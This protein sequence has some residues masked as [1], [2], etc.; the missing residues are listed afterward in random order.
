MKL[1]NIF[2]RRNLFLLIFPSLITVMLILCSDALS[3]NELTYADTNATPNCSSDSLFFATV[4]VNGVTSGQLIAYVKRDQKILIDAHRFFDIV[5]GQYF[6]MGQNFGLA[7]QYGKIISFALNNYQQGFVACKMTDMLPPAEAINNT[8]MAPL[9]FLAQAIA[10]QVNFINANQHLA[11]TTSAPSKI[12]AV[13][14][15]AKNLADALAQQN[16][17]I[18]Q[19]AINLLN[20]IELYVAGYQSDCNGNNANYPYL[21]TQT[22]PCPDVTSVSSI[23]LFYTMRSDEAFVLIGRTPP[24]CTY[25]SYRSYLYN[26]YYEDESPHRKKIYASLGD[27]QSL[28][29]MSEGRTVPD[30]F[31][32]F[33]MLISAADKKTTD[34]I[35][36]AAVASGIKENDIYVDVIPGDMVRMGL[37]EKA[38]FFNFFHRAVLFNNPADHAQ[39]TNNPS[40]EFLRI[41]PNVAAIPDYLPAPTL[42]QR[43][44]GTTEFHLN[45]GLAQLRQQIM[46]KYSTAYDAIDLTSYQW[47]PEGYEAIEKRQNVRGETRDALYLRTPFFEFQ[48]H[49]IIV[50][51][52]VNHAKTGKATYCNVG[53]YGFP[54]IN[55]LG[56]VSN[57]EFQGTAQQF[58]ADPIL[59]DSFYVWKFARMQLD[60]QTFVIPPDVNHD[61][62]GLDYGAI[63]AMVFR[64]YV[65]PATKVGPAA[66]EVIM[67]RAILF[68]PK[69]TSLQQKQ[70]MFD[71]KMRTYIV[72]EPLSSLPPEGRPL[73]LGLHAQGATVPEFIISSG[74]MQKADTENFLVV[75][76]NA[77]PHPVSQIWNAGGC[78]E[79][80]TRGTDDVGFLSALI[81]TMIKNYH[82]DTTR[83]YSTGHSGGAMMSYRLAAEFSQR[84]AAI[85]PVSGQMVYEY[86]NPEFPV[87]IIHFHGL[88]DT[89]APYQGRYGHL[90]FPPVDSALGIWREKNDCYSIPDTIY[91]EGGITGK[92]WISSGG[93][94]DIVL[95]TIQA[96]E[97]EWPR[98]STLGISATD[99]I[100]DFFKLQKRSRVTTVEQHD[101]LSIPE[102]FKLYQNYPNPFNPSTKIRYQLVKASHISLK[103][104][105]LAGQE[106]ATVVNEFQPAGEHE[107]TWQP[108][109]LPSGL[110]FCKIQAGKISETKKLIL[111]R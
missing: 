67:D 73:V 21:M 83:I 89:A 66:S 50:V 87:P 84:I 94:G 33:F 39:Y 41:T 11:I 59:A 43:G 106:I 31:N 88:A 22:P 1:I 96:G 107:V 45:D 18:Q 108:K 110:Y 104:Y 92:K 9:N 111:Q 74:L 46:N 14:P 4:S 32:R 70:F 8:V 3:P 103:I 5:G 85:G 63:A 91:K 52:G 2:S 17:T 98:T 35:R 60:A 51:F 13:I 10:G 82:V 44:T 54:A 53:C 90:Y 16:Y 79:P 20:A 6:P 56:G 65:E 95:Y 48:E 24:Q 23:P 102:Y 86:C 61:Y 57:R 100:W 42:R 81:D 47:L 12:G 49:D 76:P 80:L 77:L 97:H 15:Q 105:N 78:W 26:R 75:F 68:R 58:L 38:D 69:E 64:L 71:G 34:A 29:N 101:V 25:Y 36:N 7:V 72:H 93:K 27:T 30:S 62:T 19:G 28:Y 109:G 40:L 55:G 99:V 37:D